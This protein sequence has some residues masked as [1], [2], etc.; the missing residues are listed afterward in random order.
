MFLFPNK[1]IRIYNVPQFLQNINLD[2]WIVQSKW[3]GKRVLP[4]CDERGRITLHGRQG[5]VFKDAGWSWLDQLPLPKPWLLDGELLR[6]GRMFVWDY[7]I[8][9]G[10]KSYREPYFGRLKLL[11]TLP[12]GLGK[13]QIIETKSAVEYKSILAPGKANGLEGCVF[14]LKRATDLFG[15]TSTKE[16]PSQYKYRF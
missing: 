3:D 14:K 7:A 11:Q 8:F 6:D 13:F 2:D 5:Q 9:G 15:V 1:P 10:K 16:T 12:C 4:S